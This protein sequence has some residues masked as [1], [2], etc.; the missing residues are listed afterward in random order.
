MSTRS[1]FDVLSGRDPPPS[2]DQRPE[3]V[4][5]E[6]WAEYTAAN[7]KLIGSRTSW[8]GDWRILLIKAGAK[9]YVR[10][11]GFV[12]FTHNQDKGVDKGILAATCRAQLPSTT[13]TR[14][15]PALTLA[16]PQCRDILWAHACT[17]NLMLPSVLVE[18]ATAHSTRR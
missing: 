8:A 13:A 3:G 10:K 15:A 11:D 7:E 6:L 1:A 16:G 12:Q 5:D 18:R 14:W 9:D 17:A 2:D 4:A